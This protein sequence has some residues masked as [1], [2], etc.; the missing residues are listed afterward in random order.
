MSHQV[1]HV[2]HAEF[3]GVKSHGSLQVV[4]GN[5]HQVFLPQLPAALILH[6]KTYEKSAG[7]QTLYKLL[8]NLTYGFCAYK[9]KNKTRTYLH[10]CLF[11]ITYIVFVRLPVRLLP[12]F[13]VNVQL[14]V[15]HRRRPGA[16]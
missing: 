7:G 13:P 16:Q 8:I 11:F 2:V 6:L 4:H 5:E 10:V 9:H 3:V 12:H 1:S 15:K 14:A